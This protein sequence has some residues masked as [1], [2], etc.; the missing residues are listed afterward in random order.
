MNSV[1]T[2]NRWQFWGLIASV[3]LILMTPLGNDRISNIGLENVAAVAFVL[4]VLAC[5][6]FARHHHWTDFAQLAL[7]CWLAYSPYLL[8]YWTNTTMTSWHQLSG[9]LV[10]GFALLSIVCNGMRGRLG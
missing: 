1:L 2:G 10:A 8:G 9:A 4:L 7:G 3:F 6:E 5:G